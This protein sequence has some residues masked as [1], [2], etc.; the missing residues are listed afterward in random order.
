MCLDVG[1]GRFLPGNSGGPGN[2]HAWQ[3]ARLRSTLLRSVSQNEM[4]QIVKKLVAMSVAGDLAA[5]KLLL[6][7]T[8]G[9]PVPLDVLE[10]LAQLES[11]V[12]EQKGL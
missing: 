1:V 10:Q 11:L 9:A 7:Y 4:R 12:A 2:P 8:L 6:D 3:V 5:A